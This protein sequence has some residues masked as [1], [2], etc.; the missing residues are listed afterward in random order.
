MLLVAI[1]LPAAIYAS[2][3][4]GQLRHIREHNLRG[5]ESTALE[6]TDLL[7]N[8]RKTVGNLGK[9]TSYACEFF[10]RQNRAHLVKPATCD[11]LAKE[12]ESGF[13]T[14]S[15]R[16]DGAQGTIEIAGKLKSGNE[17]RIQV[18]VDTLLEEV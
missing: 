18:Q 9:N 2:Y 12:G 11:E 16:F 15:L 17:L 3:V 7:E 1:I 10:R 5:L 6:V 4:L 14:E 13:K 8:T